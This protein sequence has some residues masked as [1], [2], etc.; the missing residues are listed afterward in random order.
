MPES[1]R[2]DLSRAAQKRPPE[3]CLQRKYDYVIVGAG[4][5]GC[6]LANRLS[7][8]RAVSVLLDRKRSDRQESADRDAAR[9]R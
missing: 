2:L 8:D 7:E 6:A 1:P 9:H 5:A 3:L 4:S